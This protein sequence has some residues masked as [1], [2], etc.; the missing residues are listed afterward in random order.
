M[1]TTNKKFFDK[2][3]IAVNQDAN[4]KNTFQKNSTSNINFSQFNEFNTKDN[5]FSKPYEHQDQYADISNQF[6]AGKFDVGYQTFENAFPFKRRQDFNSLFSGTK[7]FN[8]NNQNNFFN[9]IN[10]EK[11]LRHFQLP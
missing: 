5:Y 11:Q 3:N 2:K 6:D 10:P 1:Q 7:N 9:E 4:I 8:I